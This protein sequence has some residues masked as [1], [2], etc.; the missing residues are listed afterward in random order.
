MHI[1]LLEGSPHRNGASHT[2]ASVFM[3]GAQAQGHTT[4]ALDVARLHLHPCRGCP[5]HV[6]TG[7]GDCIQKDDWPV[8]RA[9]V[10]AADMLVFVTPVYFYG[11]TAQLKTALDRFHCFNRALKEKNIRSALIA[12]ACRTDDEVM[13][14]LCALYQ[15]LARYLNF[16]DMGCLCARGVGYDSVPEDGDLVHRALAFGKALPE[17]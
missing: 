16:E 9:A 13:S 10:M 3:R 12:T 11:M 17:A 7:H 5:L 15:G 2:L 8:L 1:V 4:M 6:C 14:Y